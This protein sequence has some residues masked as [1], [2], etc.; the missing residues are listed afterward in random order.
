MYYRLAHKLYPRQTHD[1]CQLYFE[2]KTAKSAAL[3]LQSMEQMSATLNH[4][5]NPKHR[6]DL[7]PKPIR[8]GKNVWIGAHATVLQGVTIGDDAIVAAG[9]VVTK[10]V[11]AGVIVGG[12]PAKV[13]KQIDMDSDG[14]ASD[15]LI[16][17]QEFI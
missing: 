17:L 9:A 2:G 14:N 5:Q 8:I 1:I 13:I 16:N 7:I 12:V 4:E 3:Q 10:D 15:E 11:T 6:R